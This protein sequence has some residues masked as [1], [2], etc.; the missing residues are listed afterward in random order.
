MSDVIN[1]LILQTRR[2]HPVTSVVVTHDM[3][4][5]QKVADRVVMFYPLSRLRPG[6]PQVLFDG[7]PAELEQC[8]D[9]RVRQFIEGAAGERLSDPKGE[10][11]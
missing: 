10:S 1:E 9:P 4:T 11:P 2:Q 3:K 6:E 7:S 8:A 5:A